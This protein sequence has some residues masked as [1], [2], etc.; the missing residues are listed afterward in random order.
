MKHVY[1]RLVVNQYGG[2]G[3]GT[4]V[5]HLHWMLMDCTVSVN[6]VDKLGINVNE[7]RGGSFR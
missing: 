6:V 3:A 4:Y 7:K 5:I 2:H 1:E